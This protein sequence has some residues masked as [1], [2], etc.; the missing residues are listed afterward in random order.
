[1]TKEDHLNETFVSGKMKKRNF[2]KMF[3]MNVVG[4]FSSASSPSVSYVRWG[5]HS[6][7]V[8]SSIIYRGQN[9]AV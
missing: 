5:R 4:V 8:G 1:M 6:C 2:K 7:P 9:D 3:E